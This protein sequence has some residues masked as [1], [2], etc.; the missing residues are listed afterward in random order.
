M[1]WREYIERRPE[2][3]LGKPVIKGTRLTVEIIL[4][5]LGAGAPMED[6]LESYPFLKPEHIY[7]AQS[8]AAE[9][10]SENGLLV[11]TH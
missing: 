4:E 9:F 7:A 10:L 2:V 11:S 8:F 3:M 1:D 5:R 6:L